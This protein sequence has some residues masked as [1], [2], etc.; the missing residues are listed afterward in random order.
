MATV[1]DIANLCGVT[2]TA[3]VVVPAWRANQI[4]RYIK[5]QRDRLKDRAGTPAPAAAGQSPSW[6]E[7]ELKQF[8]QDLIDETLTWDLREVVCLFLGLG[9]TLFSY[10]LPLTV[11]M[12]GEAEGGG[13]VEVGQVLHFITILL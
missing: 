12:S 7:Q 1:A 2:G 5:R 3:M 9:L 11:S 13:E 8:E 4:L 10:L 6:L